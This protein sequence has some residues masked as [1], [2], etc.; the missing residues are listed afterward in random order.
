MCFLFFCLDVEF[1]MIYK[2]M[3]DPAFIVL[4]YTKLGDVK[5]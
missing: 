3:Q 1:I 4:C 2:I 5:S